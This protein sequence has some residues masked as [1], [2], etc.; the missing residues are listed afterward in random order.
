MFTQRLLVFDHKRINELWILMEQWRN[1]D[2]KI[3]FA[4]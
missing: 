1:F 2:I 4:C 3:Q